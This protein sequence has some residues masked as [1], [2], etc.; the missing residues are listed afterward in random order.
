[1]CLL[2]RRDR[3]QNSLSSANLNA[4]RF[5]LGELGKEVE[6]RAE[7]DKRT[8]RRIP[9]LLTGAQNGLCSD[10]RTNR[11]ALQLHACAPPDV[12]HS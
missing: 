7:E 5:W 9:Q 1:M 12:C 8:N 2:G 11:R 6:E 3:G 10:K 4:I